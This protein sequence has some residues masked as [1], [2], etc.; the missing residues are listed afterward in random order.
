PMCTS[1]EQVPRVARNA[2]VAGIDWGGGSTSATAAVIGY[3]TPHDLIFH[4]CVFR[5][6]LPG[7]DPLVVRQQVA[8]LCD[9]FQVRLIAADGA[10]NGSVYNRLL[11]GSFNRRV[12]IFGIHYSIVDQDPVPNGVLTQWT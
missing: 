12:P 5:R 11:F 6:W 3:L 2:L 9:Q 4:V 7:S 1:L 10:G 8:D